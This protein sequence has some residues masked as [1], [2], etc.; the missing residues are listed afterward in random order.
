GKGAGETKTKQAPPHQTKNQPMKQNAKPPNDGQQ[1][2]TKKT[3]AD[4]AKESASAK[5]DE[6]QG[7]PRE[8]TMK[9]LERLKDQIAK[10]DPNAIKTAEELKRN[11]PE[12]KD[13]QMTKSAEELLQGAAKKLDEMAKKNP[14]ADPNVAGGNEKPMGQANEPMTGQ[15]GA[16]NAANAKKGDGSQKAQPG[17]EKQ[18]NVTRGGSGPDGQ[19]VPDNS[20]PAEANKEFADRVANLQLEDLKSRATPE[21]RQLAGI[22][23]EEWQQFLKTAAGYQQTLQKLDRQPKNG[24]DQ[25]RATSSQLQSGGARPVQS[26]PRGRRYSSIRQTET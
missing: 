6:G 19:D 10:G 22:S 4:Q 18:K 9:D 8:P 26:G 12:S 17:D 25:L 24:P 7:P 2:A 23:D 3:P 1:G 15:G 14:D 13:P 11:L 20:K 21:K 16:E 5:D